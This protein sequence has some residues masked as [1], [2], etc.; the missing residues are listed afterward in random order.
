MPAGK[1]TG[2]LDFAKDVAGE[3]RS[4]EVIIFNDNRNINKSHR[5]WNKKGSWCALEA[6]AIIAQIKRLKKEASTNLI[7]K[8]AKNDPKPKL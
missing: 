3:T 2:L 6:G 1:G 4:K 8:Y 5:I 7:F